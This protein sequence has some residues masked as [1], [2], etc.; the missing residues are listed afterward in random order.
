MVAALAVLVLVSVL[1]E[2]VDGIAPPPPPSS[3]RC[4]SN[5]DCQLNGVCDTSTGVCRCDVA[6]TGERCHR[7]ALL[8]AEGDSG[9]QD[10]VLS[11][12][13]GSVLQNTSDGTWHMYVCGHISSC[14][15]HVG[16]GNDFPPGK[17]GIHEEAKQ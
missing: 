17:Q 6:W 9:L 10:P 2:L 4:C 16:L 13:G 15:L 8:P 3:F 14:S 12:W 11:S 7:L 1:A 5:D